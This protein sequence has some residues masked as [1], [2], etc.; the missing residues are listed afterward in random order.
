[1]PGSTW[2]T[3]GSAPSGAP[4]PARLAVLRTSPPAQRCG[5]GRGPRP[6]LAPPTRLRRGRHRTLQRQG[7]RS[8]HRAPH[9][10][11]AA[12]PPHLQRLQR[13]AGA[14]QR[15]RG[16]DQ[17]RCPRARTPP[18]RKG[19]I[20]TVPRTTTSTSPDC[21]TT[22][23]SGPTT[24]SSAPYRTTPTGSPGMI[25]DGV[26]LLELFTGTQEDSG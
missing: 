23:A 8:G 13:S 15:G 25:T 18:C 7:L 22:P 5:L 17:R 16:R 10:R 21:R 4:Q 24:T 12:E 26:A 2:S 9:T 14:R 11:G 3:C 20:P 1:M 19:A 6:H